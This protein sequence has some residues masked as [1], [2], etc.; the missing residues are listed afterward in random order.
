MNVA[1]LLFFG[2][3]LGSLTLFGQ[4]KEDLQEIQRDVAQLQDQVSTL[5][6]SE[7]A[8]MAVLQGMLQQA[9]DGSN[10]V[11]AALTALERD[12]DAKLSDQQT[13]L[14][15]P[16]ATMGTKVDQVSDDFRSVA[17]NVAD[18]VHRMDS[19]DSKLADIS[20][21]VRTLSTPPT[22]PP[23][24][25]S[26]VPSTNGVAGAP[27][28]LSAEESYQNAYRDYNGANYTLAM[29]E[30]SDFLKYFG[31]TANAPAA[32]YYIGQMYYSAGQFSDAAK[33]FDAVLERYPENEKSAD[34]LYYKAVSLLKEGSHRT[35]AGA[36]FKAYLK[37]YPGGDHVA[38]AHSNLKMLGLEPARS[39][40]KKRQ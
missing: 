4:R 29:Q 22:A 14:V 6:K 27:P 33:A 19:L 30:F 2:I 15:A 5:Q 1:R 32:Q 11:T 18:L 35:D 20:S 3:V 16:I 31:Q 17:A 7:D 26:A 36:E 8:K 34:A 12:I 28:G 40:A 13:K 24:A 25:S 39:S 38:Q 37:R 10:R 9:V 21:A 23:G